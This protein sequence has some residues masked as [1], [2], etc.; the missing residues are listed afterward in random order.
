MRQKSAFTLPELL[1]VI[2]ILA[3]LI[4]LVLP[5]VQKAREAAN[6]LHCANNMKQLALGAQVFHESHNHIPTG[7]VGPHRPKPGQPSFGWGPD[8]YGWSWLARLL[9]YIE[10]DSLYKQGRIPQTTLRQSGIADQRIGLF[11]CPSDSAYNAGPRTVAGNLDGFSVGHTNY[12]GVSGA[13]W[14][15]DKGERKQINT[16]WRNQGTNGSYDGLIQGDGM[17]YRSDYQRKLSFTE[18][19]DGV[20]NTFM[21]GEDVPEKNRWCSWPYSN[22]AYGTC[23]IPPNVKRPS[24][25]EYHPNNW[26]NTWSFRSRHPGGLQFAYAD[27]SVHFISNSIAL[28][29]YRAMATISG[30]ELVKPE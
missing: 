4:G 16:D 22:N 24:G 13:N 10:Q 21:L 5:A 12:K 26:H 23:A 15:D 3:A 19:D 29:T 9:P 2:A 6:R 11:L 28:P 7:Q 20:S 14:G 30:A 25:G 8:S 1:V 17:M 27:G 18:V